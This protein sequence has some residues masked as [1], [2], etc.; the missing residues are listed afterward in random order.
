MNSYN[1][2]PDKPL[3]NLHSAV[4]TVVQDCDV[5]LPPAAS[6]V[7]II[8]DAMQILTCVVPG[9]LESITQNIYMHTE[10][11]SVIVP[12]YHLFIQVL[13]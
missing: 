7:T 4:F 2:F 10:Q 12:Y 3:G 13:R 6:N 1:H 9:A 8:Y 11:V 5:T